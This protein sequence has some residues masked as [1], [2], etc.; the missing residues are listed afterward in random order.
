MKPSL[1]VLAVL[2]LSLAAPAYAE[3]P[4]GAAVPHEP[5]PDA[6]S[7]AK[8]GSTPPRAGNPDP[9]LAQCSER[10]REESQAAG[11][12]AAIAEDAAAH[13]RRIRAVVRLY[14]AAELEKTKNGKGCL[15]QADTAKQLLAADE[16]Q[17][18]SGSSTR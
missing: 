15:A 10:I 17:P 7:D 13:A 12:P 18:S 11:N 14:V 4:Q 16:P 2:L 3:G 8:S 6:P 1:P 9:Q 5:T